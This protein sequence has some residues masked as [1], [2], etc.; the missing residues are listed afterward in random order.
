M[1]GNQRGSR[2]GNNQRYQQ[3]NRSNRPQENV[4]SQKKKNI[5]YFSLNKI[6]LYLAVL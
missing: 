4:K 6:Q 2:G 5:K 3:N 1:Q